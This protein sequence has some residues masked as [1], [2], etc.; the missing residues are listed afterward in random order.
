MPTCQICKRDFKQF[1]NHYEY[2]HGITIYE[3]A[4]EYLIPAYSIKTEYEVNKKSAKQI[5][6]EI[7]ILTN[8]AW[9]P[10]KTIILKILKD[11]KVKIR[12]TSEA[13][14]EWSALQGGP[15]NKDLKKADHPSIQQYADKRMGKDNPYY[16]TAPEK[17]IDSYY[18]RITPAEAS[19]VRGKIS[20]T[21]KRKFRSGEIKKQTPEF[22][23]TNLAKALL[24][25]KKQFDEGVWIPPTKRSSIPEKKIGTALKSLNLNYQDQYHIGWHVF[26]FY[27]PQYSLIIEF[28]GT[29]WHCDPRKYSHDFYHTL[30]KKTAKQIWGK[31]EEKKQKLFHKN[32]ELLVIWEEDIKR[33]TTDELKTYVD[34]AIK[35]K[36][37]NKG[38]ISDKSL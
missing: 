37:N 23:K 28:N 24:V 5:A 21:L 9:S 22:Y 6:D 30:R 10:L 15:W 33:L 2:I 20:D 38:S 26:D 17:R 3:Y 31:D 7:K 35:N 18:T 12:N 19:I 32:L 1:K 27:L 16:K 36:I 8:K 4:Q 14:K 13:I 34:E 11:E 29:Y 25:L